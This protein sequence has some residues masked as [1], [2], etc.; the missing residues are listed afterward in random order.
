LMYVRGNPPQVA[1]WG[2]REIFSLSTLVYIYKRIRIVS[3]CVSVCLYVCLLAFFLFVFLPGSRFA[4]L[5]F[6]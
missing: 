5:P 4:L 6:L 1:G 2:K 3:V